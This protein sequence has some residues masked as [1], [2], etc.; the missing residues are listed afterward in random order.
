MIPVSEPLLSGRES[1]YVGAC[2]KT[3]WISSSG[4][5]VEKFEQEWSRYCERMYG[6][7]VCNGTAALQAAV[8]ALH[9]GKGDEVIL[10]TFTIIWPSN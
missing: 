7:S 8:A 1:E 2:L 10:P 6:V 4:P 3:G 9:I 5:M